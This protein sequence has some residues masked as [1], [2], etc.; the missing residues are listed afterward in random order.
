MLLG[1]S[2]NMYLNAMTQNYYKPDGEG[3]LNEDESNNFYSE[4]S[5]QNQ[6]ISRKHVA[7]SKRRKT[8]QVVPI[9]GLQLTA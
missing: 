1:E 6:I 9:R 7:L 2:Y 5:I 8:N 3:P 4:I